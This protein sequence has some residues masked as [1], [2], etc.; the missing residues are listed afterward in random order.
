MS[1]SEIS[2]PKRFV[3]QAIICFYRHFIKILLT[4]ELAIFS[5]ARGLS[6]FDAAVIKDGNGIHYTDSIQL[7]CGYFVQQKWI[8]PHIIVTDYCSLVTEF[9][10]D[11]VNSGRKEWMTFFSRY[12]ELQSRIPVFRLFRFCCQIL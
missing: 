4:D 5:F 11:K 3:S 10:S 1:R 6:S 9:R 7:L 2:T 8:A 12:Y